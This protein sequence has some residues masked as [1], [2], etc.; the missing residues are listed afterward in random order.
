MLLFAGKEAHLKQEALS[1]L[2]KSL[3]PPG[4]EDLNETVLENPEPDAIIAAAETLPFIA[5]RR[6]IIVR[7]Y[8]A[9]VG[10]SDLDK[11][12]QDY[13][14]Q[15]PSTAVLLFYCV[16]E[17]NKKKKLYTAIEKMN[18]L[19]IFDP[20]QKE[21]LTAFVVDAFRKRGL[22]CS[23]QAAEF[24]HFYV[25]GDTNLLLTDIDKIAAWHPDASSVSV[26]DIRTM[27]VP[28]AE[29]TVFQITDAVAA[30]QGSL[31]LRLL[32]QE[33][34]KKNEPDKYIIFLTRQFRLLQHIKIMQYEK[35]SVSEMQNTM[36]LT[37]F[38]F[39][40]YMEQAALWTP[41]QVK[42]ALH[43]CL[44][45]ELEIRRGRL[46]P[47]DALETLILKL[48]FIRRPLPFPADLP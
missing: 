20:L 15:V 42:D 11:M 14:P 38:I 4:M 2:R 25:G 18:G 30:G 40:R 17:V 3:L 43:F 35:Q 5:D 26:E 39:S 19:V 13:L 24:M 28:S 10:K 12:L 1:D 33:L 29:A 16:L 32:R 7:D 46:S 22:A 27:A 23:R 31:A 6:L 8:A 45:T 21:A 37:R 41:R 47:G 44:D 34:R 9:L 36:G 48:L